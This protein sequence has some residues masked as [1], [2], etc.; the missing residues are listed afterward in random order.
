MTRYS[1]QPRYL[2]HV[3][4]FEF[5]YFAKNMSKNKNLFGNKITDEI[6]KASI[7]SRTN[8]TISLGT[9][10]NDTTNIRFDRE[11]PKHI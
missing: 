9:V 6:T 8:P 11:I 10:T 2:I 5:L 3:K 7:T 1:I 4:G